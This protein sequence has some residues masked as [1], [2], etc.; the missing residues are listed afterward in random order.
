M[1]QSDNIEKKL[2]LVG[3][4]DDHDDENDDDDQDL[5]EYDDMELL[6]ML[7]TLREDMEDLGVSTLAEVT[8]RIAMLHKKLDK[9]I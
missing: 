2:Y 7:E 1:D 5:D 6:D 8:Q 4:D 9:K 3:K